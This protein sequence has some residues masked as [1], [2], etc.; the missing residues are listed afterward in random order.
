MLPADNKSKADVVADCQKLIAE[1]QAYV[2]KSKSLRRVFF[3]I[4]GIYYQAE[5]KGQTI[6]W[7]VP[8]QFSQNIPTDVDFRVMLT[9]LEFY[10]TL[11]GF[12]NFK[13]YIHLS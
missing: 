9:F 3:S 6:T 8:Y 11:V 2:V 4:K 10:R 13:L 7:V 5:I 12:V 1:F